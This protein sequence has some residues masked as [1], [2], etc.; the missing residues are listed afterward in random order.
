MTRMYLFIPVL[1]FLSGCAA[2]DGPVTTES[3]TFYVDFRDIIFNAADA[4]EP[5]LRGLGIE[6]V[7]ISIITEDGEGTEAE[8]RGEILPADV[9]TAEGGGY[10]HKGF[11]ISGELKSITAQAGN[12]VS[13]IDN[14]SGPWNYQGW[15]V[16]EN[17]GKVKIDFSVNV[18]APSSSY[19]QLVLCPRGTSSPA[20]L[21]DSGPRTD[22]ATDRGAA[23]LSRQIALQLSPADVMCIDIN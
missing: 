14:N 8:T 18:S 16:F 12:L 23:L 20:I 22:P 19:F 17:I 3:R 11:T 7:S 4:E 13:S 15:T 2:Y 21:V 9:D 5:E 6:S 10:S 1:L